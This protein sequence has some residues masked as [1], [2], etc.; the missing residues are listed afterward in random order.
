MRRPIHIVTEIRL[1]SLGFRAEYFLLFLQQ[2]S[3]TAARTNLALRNRRYR[4]ENGDCIRHDDHHC[5]QR[6]T[7]R[8]LVNR[9]NKLGRVNL[10]SEVPDFRSG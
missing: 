2:Q 1:A 4:S 9:T 5:S 8:K 7:S 6:A 3:V 10:D